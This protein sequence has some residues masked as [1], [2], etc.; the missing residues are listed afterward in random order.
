MLQIPDDIAARFELAMGASAVGDAVRPHLWKW[1]R[2]YLD[3]VPSTG[4]N[5]RPSHTRAIGSDQAIQLLR[6]A[7]C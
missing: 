3:F 4:L 7:S 5:R 6:P 2:F 1:L